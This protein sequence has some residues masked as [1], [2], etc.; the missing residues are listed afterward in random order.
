MN[1]TF[2]QTISAKN[3]YL[4]QFENTQKHTLLT[5]PNKIVI[6]F[7]LFQN[8]LRKKTKRIYLYII[9]II[10]KCFLKYIY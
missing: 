8:K 10:Y 7:Y 9:H 4:F 1:I 2:L 6:I 5:S 3:I